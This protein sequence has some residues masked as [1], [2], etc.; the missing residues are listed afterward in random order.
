[1][2][3][4]TENRRVGWIPFAVPQSRIETPRTAPTIE[5]VRGDI[6]GGMFLRE[7]DSIFNINEMKNG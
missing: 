6:L 3:V 5:H 4:G 1:M 7:L 2:N